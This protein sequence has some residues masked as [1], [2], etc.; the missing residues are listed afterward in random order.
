M[1]II[2]IEDPVEMRI[3]DIDGFD[4]ADHDH[5]TDEERRNAFRAALTALSYNVS[6]IMIVEN[7]SDIEA[8]LMRIGSH[9]SP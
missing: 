8:R 7:I 6:E 5:S 4:V 1:N 3:C 9:Q 2:N